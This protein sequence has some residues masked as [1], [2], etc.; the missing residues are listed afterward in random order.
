MFVRRRRVR[1][2]GIPWRS[3]VAGQRAAVGARATH[4]QLD[5]TTNQ[6]RCFRRTC[7]ADDV[8]SRHLDQL[9][10]DSILKGRT[11]M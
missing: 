6:Q 3:L 2:E 10:F 1:R 11:L 7:H 4:R 5:P 9:D 8:G